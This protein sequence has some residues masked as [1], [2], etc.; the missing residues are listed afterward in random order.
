M[1]PAV[2]VVSSECNPLAN[3][4]PWSEKDG[5]WTHSQS[6]RTTTIAPTP[7]PAIGSVKF[8]GLHYLFTLT[9]TLNPNSNPNFDITLT[10]TK[11]LT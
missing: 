3:L 9:L 1:C 2:E 7:P 8:Q 4:Q 10:L 6:G 11:T 5:V